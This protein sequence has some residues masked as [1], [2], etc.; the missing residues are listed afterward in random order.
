VGKEMLGSI[1]LGSI[2]K[3]KDVKLTIAEYHPG[4]QK[5]FCDINEIGET[6]KKIMQNY[7]N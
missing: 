7:A 3:A 2:L 1:Y 5:V 6:A 4:E